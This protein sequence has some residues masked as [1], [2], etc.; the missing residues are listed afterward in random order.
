MI[1]AVKSPA[2]LVIAVYLRI[3]QEDG[4]DESKSIGSQRD[5]IKRYI[6]SQED[7]R[8]A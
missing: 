2:A 6:A 1:N 8:G 7:F 5:L 3:S 4:N